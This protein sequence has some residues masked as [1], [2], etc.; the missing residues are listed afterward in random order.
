MQF[1][2]RRIDNAVGL[3]GSTREAHRLSTCLCQIPYAPFRET[4]SKTVPTV[5]GLLGIG[6]LTT[7]TLS[8]PDEVTYTT[9]L[10]GDTATDSSE[11]HHS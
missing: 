5:G 1:A 9:F 11:C 4:E 7:L 2:R 10:L 3:A 6:T 8:E